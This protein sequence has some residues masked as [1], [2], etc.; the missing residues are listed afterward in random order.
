MNTFLNINKTTLEILIKN[1]FLNFGSF[2]ISKLLDSIKALGFFYA[3]SGG[4]SISIEDFK[5]SQTVAN[6]LKSIDTK[7]INKTLNWQEGKIYD[8]ERFDFIINSWNIATEDIKNE[9]IFCYK[10]FDPLNCLF[11]MSNSGAR[12]NMSQIR[13]L[14]GLRGLMSDQEGNVIDVPI[15]QSFSKGLSTIDYVISGYGARKGVV[16]T[17]VKTAWAGYLTRRLIFLAQDIIIRNID[18]KTNEGLIVSLNL[19]TLDTNLLGHYLL[20]IKNKYIQTD[21]FIFKYKNQ[22]INEDLIK[23][24]KLLDFYNK[25]AYFLKIRSTIT[26]QDNSVCQ[27]CYGYDLSRNEI[28]SLGENV[29]TIAGQSIGEPG[30]QLTMRTFHTGGVFTAQFLKQE[31][32][33]IFGKFFL[34]KKLKVNLHKKKKKNRI[35]IKKLLKPVSSIILNWSGTINKVMLPDNSP[36]SSSKSKYL[37]ETDFFIGKLAENTFTI[38]KKLKPLTLKHDVEI[39]ESSVKL[40]HIPINLA[41]FNTLYSKSSKKAKKLALDSN[42]LNIDNIDKDISLKYINANRQN[43]YINTFKNHLRLGIGQIISKSQDFKKTFQTNILTYKGYAKTKLIS[44]YTG[45]SYISKNEIFFL[46]PKFKYYINLQKLSDIFSNKN[47]KFQIY[48]LLQNYQYIDQYSQLVNIIIFPLFSEKVFKVKQC[49]KN[50]ELKMF[51]R[52]ESQIF[53]FFFNLSKNCFSKLFYTQS[54][55]RYNQLLFAKN[56]ALFLKRNGSNHF[57]H[58]FIKLVLEKGTIFNPL[59]EFIEADYIIAKS[60]THPL[61]SNDIVQGLPKVSQLIDALHPQLEHKCILS[62]APGILLHK[63]ILNKL[64][65]I[66][67]DVPYSNKYEYKTTSNKDTQKYINVFENNMYV[68]QH[69]IKKLPLLFF[70]NK[71][72]QYQLWEYSTTK[73]ID[74]NPKFNEKKKDFNKDPLKIINCNIKIIKSFNTTENIKM[75][76]GIVGSQFVFIQHPKFPNI[77]LDSPILTTSL[78]KRIVSRYLINKK[79]NIKDKNLYTFPITD[80]KFQYFLSFL[81]IKK[82]LSLNPDN[83]LYILKEYNSILSYSTSLKLLHN[84]NDYVDI[85]EPLSEGYIDPHELLINLY[86]YNVLHYKDIPRALYKSV[87]KFRLILLNSILSIYES[88]GVNIASKHIEIMCKQLTSKVLINERNNFIET[89]CLSK[90]KDNKKNYIEMNVPFLPTEE[91]TLTIADS[92][93]QVYCL[94]KNSYPDLRLPSYT[95]LFKSSITTSTSRPGF[96]SAASFQSTKQV[97]AKAALLGTNDW[98][99]GVKETVMS[100]KQIFAGTTYLGHYKANYSLNEIQF[101][102]II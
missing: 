3:T 97:L 55:I 68:F 13:Q 50:H 85:G 22:L 79:K 49:S 102:Q 5:I 38:N 19:K 47:R 62:K 41:E 12:G 56:Q 59:S 98:V 43:L 9:I 1:I 92:I 88:Q 101:Y 10:F 57:Y 96:L 99:S 28:V 53:N 46:T 36:L 61:Q 39:Y 60:I 75:P 35:L 80:K 20:D 94:L 18:C 30:T 100:G 15:K 83:S 54:K 91:I 32:A 86:N 67:Y 33:L 23:T 64:N 4:I 26:C 25:N 76:I 17:A 45:I 65:Y 71:L 14:I 21:N 82:K 51:I 7:A 44:Q 8:V 89:Y 84:I 87:Y 42:F 93:Y 27:K 73:K 78:C 24:L 2:S 63:A 70:Q 72:W 77:T 11:L 31:K 90:I 34:P 29:G 48:T 52:G 95:P 74:F 58:N 16:D 6:I 66:V 69:F 40:A 81:K 37:Y